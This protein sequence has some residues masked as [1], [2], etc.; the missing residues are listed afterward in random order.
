[1]KEQ[2]VTFKVDEGLFK[3]LNRIPNRSEFI[4]NSILKSLDNT[5]PLCNGV[6]ILNPCQKEHWEQFTQHHHVAECS[7]CNSVY[8]TCD[9]S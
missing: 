1:M 7:D 4:R 5:C 3:I 8:L 6:G 9:Q 2:I